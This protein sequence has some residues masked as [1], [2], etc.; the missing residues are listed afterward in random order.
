MWCVS[1]TKNK[2]HTETWDSVNT[3]N[4]LAWTYIMYNPAQFVAVEKR[5]RPAVNIS[6]TVQKWPKKA[7]ESLHCNVGMARTQSL[8]KR[9]HSL[10]ICNALWISRLGPMIY[11][12][13]PW[14][15]LVH[16]RARESP[17]LWLV[18]SLLFFKH[19]Y[20]YLSNSCT[21]RVLLFRFDRMIEPDQGS[22]LKVF[23]W[24]L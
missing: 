7:P 24:E 5:C 3:L 16:R 21:P 17:L 2:H 12:Q 13:M 20:A 11:L 6:W 18:G 4:N 1:Q 10:V 8:S 23:H 9:T 19:E 15:S 22:E 14:H